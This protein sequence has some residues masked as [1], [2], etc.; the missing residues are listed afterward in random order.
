MKSF[1]PWK[2]IKQQEKDAAVEHI[3][4]TD[5]GYKKHTGQFSKM[6]ITY[7]PQIPASRIPSKKVAQEASERKLKTQI[8]S[9]SVSLLVIFQAKCTGSTANW[10]QAGLHRGLIP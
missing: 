4:E 8:C 5:T 9:I 7:S 6:Q 2:L 1:A 3:I 10:P